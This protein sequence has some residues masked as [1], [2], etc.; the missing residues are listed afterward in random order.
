MKRS[1]WG[2]LLIVLL[3][4]ISLFGT[5]KTSSK[6]KIVKSKEKSVQLTASKSG[7]PTEINYQGWVC[8]ATDTTGLTGKYNMIFRLYDTPTG[9]TPLWSEAQDSV[10]TNKG[11]FSVLLG[12]VTTIPDTIFNGTYLYLETQV[13]S[14]VLSP[15][16]KIVSVGYAIKSK[17]ADNSINADTANYARNANVD[18]VDSSGHSLYTDST[19]K[20]L[21]SWDSDKLD[22]KHST[23]FV[24]STGDTKTGNYLINGVL[25]ID[26]TTDT[27][28]IVIRDFG[29]GGGAGT[30]A[31]NINS[32]LF[33]ADG[34]INLGVN[35]NFDL[36]SQLWSRDD[37]TKR[38]SLLELGSAGISMYVA[39]SGTNPI[40]WTKG[41]QMQKESEAV[42][43]NRLYLPTIFRN[44]QDDVSS[45]SRITL[46]AQA[47]SGTNTTFGIGKI[48]YIPDTANKRGSI[49]FYSYDGGADYNEVMRID[50][51]KKVGILDSIPSKTLSVKGQGKFTDT[52]WGKN[53][54]DSGNIFTS[55]NATADTFIGHHKGL[56]DSSKNSTQTQRNLL[57]L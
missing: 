51:S 50:S 17:N 1:F 52:L 27:G 30:I 21:Y 34:A 14:E 25:T 22:G 46:T 45:N 44:A 18:Y 5:G 11:V 29:T 47:T 8:T 6:V 32:Y 55:G 12:S 39:N 31:P 7:I 3:L 24:S 16:K 56:T 10:I 48:V 35:S 49:A 57:C 4:P 53:I 2:V 33:R 13:E 36:A 37:M 54:V 42:M 38:A 9:L 43:Y 41:F 19:A 23:D 15:R 40:N 28:H 26:S 20:S